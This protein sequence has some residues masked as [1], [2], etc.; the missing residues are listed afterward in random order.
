MKVRAEKYIP[1]I[2]AEFL[3]FFNIFSKI[4]ALNVTI[5]L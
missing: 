4:P 5:K 3:E 1:E 2:L